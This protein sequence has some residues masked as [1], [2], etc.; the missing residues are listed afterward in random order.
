MEFL[1]L[2]QI[3]ELETPF[4][5][6]VLYFSRTLLIGWVSHT[7]STVL[8]PT[9]LCAHERPGLYRAGACKVASLCESC[10]NMGV[11][12]GSNSKFTSNCPC[13]RRGVSRVC[14]RKL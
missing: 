3:I 5:A 11:A 8:S 4:R 6:I 12:C 7:R 2:I 13:H 1:E 9:E 10:V 14:L